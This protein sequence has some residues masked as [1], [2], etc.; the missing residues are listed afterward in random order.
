MAES[1]ETTSDVLLESSE[2][3]DRVRLTVRDTGVG[4]DRQSMDSVFDAFYTTKS[5]GMGIGLPVSRSIVERHQGSR[6][7]R[8]KD[9]VPPSRFPFRA[10]PKTSLITRSAAFVMVKRSVYT[11]RM[12]Y[13]S[14]FRKL[15]SAL[16]PPIR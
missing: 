9:Q 13:P 3:A 1:S 16:S 7:R 11:G 8:T 4:L 5:G 15:S 14:W 10:C 6:E 2:N 12:T